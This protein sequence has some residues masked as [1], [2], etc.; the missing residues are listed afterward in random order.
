MSEK[1]GLPTK[2]VPREKFN[3]SHPRP[4]SPPKPSPR[5]SPAKPKKN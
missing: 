4:V 1:K 2:P 5:P 3:E